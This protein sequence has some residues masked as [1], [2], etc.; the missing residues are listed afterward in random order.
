MIPRPSRERSVQYLGV[1]LHLFM[2]FQFHPWRTTKGIASDHTLTDAELREC[3]RDFHDY[4]YGWLRINGQPLSDND[5]IWLDR[6]LEK[7]I[8]GPTRRT[9]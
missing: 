3:L 4:I 9:W 1:Y 6:E 8:M 5:Y 7:K 2:R